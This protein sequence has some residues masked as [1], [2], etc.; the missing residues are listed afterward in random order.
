[1]ES[2]IGL[3]NL[4]RMVKVPREVGVAFV[5]IGTLS[6]RTWWSVLLSYKLVTWHTYRFKELATSSC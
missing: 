1:M 3:K 5:E 6:N 2:Q 4:N